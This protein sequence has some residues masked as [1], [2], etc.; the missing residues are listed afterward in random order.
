MTSSCIKIGDY[1]SH[2]L[3]LMVTESIDYKD[4][5][6]FKSTHSETSIVICLSLHGFA[7][8]QWNRGLYWGEIP[9]SLIIKTCFFFQE[10]PFWN[11]HRQ[12]IEATRFGPITIESRFVS[13]GNPDII[14]PQMFAHTNRPVILSFIDFNLFSCI[15]VFLI[16]K[17]LGISPFAPYCSLIVFA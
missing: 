8:L 1:A 17:K 5:F 7:Q 13:R 2:P 9:I 3:Q 11:K 16:T 6:F 15:Y 4:L 10:Y 14:G 12:I